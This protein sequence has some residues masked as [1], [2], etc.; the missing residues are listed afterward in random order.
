MSA[1]RAG[2]AMMHV[3]EKPSVAREISNILGGKGSRSRAGASKFNPIHEFEYDLGGAK[4]TMRVTSVTGH[5]MSSDF[6]P[7]YGWSSCDPF[8]LF[9]APIRKQ[10]PEKNKDIERNLQQVARLSTWLVLWL[11]CDREGENIGAEVVEVCM[12]ANPRLQI[13]RARFSSLT[14]GEITHAVHNLTNIDMGAVHAV[15][16]RSE[17]DL[18]AGAA[19]SRLQTFW[20]TRYFN[21]LKDEVITYGPC[22]FPTLGFVIERYLQIE[23]HIAESFWVIDCVH[24]YVYTHTHT[25]TLMLPCRL[26]FALFGCFMSICLCFF[27]WTKN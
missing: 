7:G 9:T 18:R 5:L 27:V 25:H 17:I 20:L 6:A 8:D 15:D 3:A 1:A 11:D 16:A 14:R 24:K 21:Q 26:H 23:N 22:Q 19:F 4:H 10:V 12:K 13:S 2:A